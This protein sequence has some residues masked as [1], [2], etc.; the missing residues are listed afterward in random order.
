M[1][2]FSPQKQKFIFLQTNEFGAGSIINKHQV[3]DASQKSR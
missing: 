2:K 3:R 1:I